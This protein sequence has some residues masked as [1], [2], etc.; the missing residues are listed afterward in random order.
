MTVLRNEKGLELEFNGRETYQ[1]LEYFNDR[2]DYV[3]YGTKNT[4]RKA[5]NLF[6]SVLK[7]QGN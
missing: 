4:L 6:N 3:I 1:V 5:N 7:S 2:E